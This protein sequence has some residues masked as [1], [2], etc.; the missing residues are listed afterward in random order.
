MSRLLHSHLLNENC[1]DETLV[2]DSSRHVWRDIARWGIAGAVI[3]MAHAAGAYALHVMTPQDLPEGEP[4]VAIMME[5]DPIPQAAEAEDIAQAPQ[6]ETAIDPKD[7]EPE[8]VDEVEVTKTAEP[9]RDTSETKEPEP[10]ELD[11]TPLEDQPEVKEVAEAPEV[12]APK[13]QMKP[14]RIEKP[15]SEVVEQKQ[16]QPAK[17]Q[18][19]ATKAKQT[20][21]SAAVQSNA[22]PSTKTAS[23]QSRQSS[24]AAGASTAKWNSKLQAHLE[25]NKRYLLRRFG[26]S[27]KGIV[28]LNFTIDPAGNVLSTRVQRSS[29]N[30]KLDQLALEMVKR[31]SPMPVPPPAIAK[32]RLPINV[33]VKFN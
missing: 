5:L 12:V 22:Q 8:P 28:G 9:E 20:Q 26:S 27:N 11:E 7:I 15:K 25:R 3:L 29:G 33:P 2:M 32:P 6:V 24:A 10:V 17:P 4:P 19:L 14:K 21:K 1:K 30:Q 18:R 13:P 16:N 23:D 31:A